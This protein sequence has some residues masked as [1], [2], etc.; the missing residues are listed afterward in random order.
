MV[1]I[2]LLLVA[3]PKITIHKIESQFS[4]ECQKFFFLKSCS[5]AWRITLLLQQYIMGL[6]SEF[7]MTQ[8]K[9]KGCKL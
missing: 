6:S 2:C 5:I 3:T 7:A 9:Q 1:F 8:E 4:F